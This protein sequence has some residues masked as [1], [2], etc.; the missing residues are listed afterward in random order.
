MSTRSVPSWRQ[1]CGRHQ[2][3]TL[4]TH[5]QL[6]YYQT[7][8]HAP[9]IGDGRAEPVATVNSTHS[10]ITRTG[11]DERG[12]DSANWSAAATFAVLV[13]AVSTIL[14]GEGHA[15]R[16]LQAWACFAVPVLA[17]LA[18]RTGMVATRFSGSLRAVLAV[19]GGSVLV[20][21]CT[22][23]LGSTSPQFSTLATM[24]A[25]A[26]LPAGG[27]LVLLDAPVESGSTRW[28]RLAAACIAAA[29]VWS[30]ATATSQYLRHTDP[31]SS[32]KSPK[33]Q[34]QRRAV[35]GAIVNA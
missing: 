11:L 27:V 17:A 4:A 31:G 33:Q 7:H 16:A 13:L 21:A 19:F 34:R 2:P 18:I 1:V 3:K 8:R 6:A 14:H 24:V 22:M 20:F 35:P 23:A 28:S 5:R 30:S 10:P 9:R 15:F 12:F 32:R 26:F 29:F 25:T